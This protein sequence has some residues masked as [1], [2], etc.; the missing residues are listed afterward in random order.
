MLFAIDA[1]QVARGLNPK[2][3]CG[4]KS[5]FERSRHI[6]NRMVLGGPAQDMD[7]RRGV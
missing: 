6:H 1:P 5:A 4:V 3:T 2:T 7:L